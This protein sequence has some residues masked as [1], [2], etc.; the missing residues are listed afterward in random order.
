MID[1]LEIKGSNG[2]NLL[3]QLKGQELWLANSFLNEYEWGYLNGLVNST[4]AYSTAGVVL[5]NT[6]SQ[7]LY[8][9][10]MGILTTAKLHLAGL[11]S[12]ITIQAYFNSSSLTHLAGSLVNTDSAVLLLKGYAEPDGIKKERVALYNKMRYVIPIVQWRRESITLALAPSSTYSI[13]L[14][15]IKG[16]SAGLFLT[17]R[18]AVITGANQATYLNQFNNIDVQMSDGSSMLG[19]YQ[20]TVNEHRLEYAEQFANS[21]G[22]NSNFLFIPFCED[23]VLDVHTGSNSGFQSFD[24]FCKFKFTTLSTLGAGSYIIDVYSLNHEHLG[25]SDGEITVSST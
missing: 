8:I 18:A 3:C 2:N 22:S 9:P 19:F 24:G 16:I 7:D 17:M 25:I 4:S 15:A 6:A 21:F 10:L 5:A 20:R 23:V 11:R 13:T 14:N 1:R 12:E